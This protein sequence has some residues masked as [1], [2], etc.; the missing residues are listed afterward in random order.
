MTDTFTPD[1]FDDL[2]ITLVYALRDSLT[3]VTPL[4][5]WQGRAASA[6]ATAAAGADSIQQAV[7]IACRKLQID[8][9][10]A[11]AAPRIV[12]VA[13]E[14]APHFE[15]WVQHIDRTL[16]YI[17]ALARADNAAKR[18]ARKA[19]REATETPIF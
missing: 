6:I 3:E 14:L 10:A 11:E 7:T 17:I 1:R 16:V 13:R 4:D 12:A 18:E 15:A 9:I 5:F 8:G 2:T 19:A